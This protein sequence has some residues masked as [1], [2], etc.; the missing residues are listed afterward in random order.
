[1]ET[2]SP[3]S[4]SNVLIIYDATKDRSECELQ[5]TVHNVRVR[6]DILRPGNTL[7]VLGILHTLHHPSK[8]G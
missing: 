7:V 3:L 8:C 1:M 4:P 2:V 5:R 6:G